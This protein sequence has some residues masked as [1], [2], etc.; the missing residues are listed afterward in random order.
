[1]R[2]LIE[3]MLLDDIPQ[4]QV[5]ET[6]SF[7]SPW[8]AQA[9][10]Q[11][12]RTNRLAHYIVLREIAE[13]TE[14]AKASVLSVNVS[15]PAR[16]EGIGP[17]LQHLFKRLTRQSEPA[18]AVERPPIAGFA[19]IWMMVGEAHLVTIA[20][21]TAHR[22]K[23]L[24]ELILVSMIDLACILGAERMTLE[25][26]VSNHVAQSLY[27]KYGFKN[28]G[29]RRR[30]YSDNGEDALIMT[31][32]VLTSASYQHHYQELKRALLSRLRVSFNMV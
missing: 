1:M 5:I 10:E 26:R 29:V 14:A 15:D 21:G 4:V 32:D 30:Y 7:S 2:Y 12:L 28:E 25:V 20:V 18:T 6:Q 3:Q 22:G 11:D 23:G 19:G 27:R 13:E 24:G 8:S 16:Q 31:T 9:Y 17:T